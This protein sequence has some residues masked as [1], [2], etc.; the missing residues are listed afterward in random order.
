[1]A[2]LLQFNDQTITVPVSFDGVDFDLSAVSLAEYKLYDEL[3][4]SVILSLGLASGITKSGNE[5]TITLTDTQ[6][7]ELKGRYYHELVMEDPVNLRSTVFKGFIIFE[8]TY[9]S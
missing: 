9:N 3:K 6:S 2:N 4:N 5:F 7:E 8:A 1:M